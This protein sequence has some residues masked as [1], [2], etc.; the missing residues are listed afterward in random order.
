MRLP[1]GRTFDERGLL[2]CDA[3]AARRYLGACMTGLNDLAIDS[4]SERDGSGSVDAARGFAS[5]AE[6]ANWYDDWL[7][8]A[9]FPLW[10]NVGAD[11]ERGGFHEALSVDGEPRPGPRRARVQARQTYVYATA[12][13]LGWDG[14]W[15]EAAWHGANFYIGKYRRPDGLF[16]TLIGLDGNVADETPMLYDQAFTLL[17]TATLHKVDPD[18]VDLRDVALG[19]RRG[20]DSMRSPN[21]GYIENIAYPYQANAHMHLLEGALAWGE[22]DGGGWD[23]MAD[24]IVEMTLRVFIDPKERFLRE[25]F[26][27][28]WRPV[29][30]ADGRLMEPG[31]QFE[32]AWLLDRWGRARG[33]ADAVEMARSLYRAGRRGV[34]RERNATL[35]ELWDDF[36]VKDP[37]ARFWPQTERLKADILFGCEEDQLA[38][39]SSLRRYLK[40]PKSGVW[41]DKMRLDGTFLDEPA[42]ATSFY[43]VLCACLELL[44]VAGH[45]EGC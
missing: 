3:P 13:A 34:D 45:G 38:A 7:R 30:G 18:R 9:A 37:I 43:H 42:P 24:E 19:V 16:R 12:G 35:N 25:F 28:E 27:A 15:R 5:L 14:P 1:Y 8:T 26:D 17:A 44:R 10:W 31:H 39:A 11:L 41:Y 23:A 4:V 21:G 2:E 40:T 32:W 33:R 36:T 6:A 22:I 29:Q 20:L